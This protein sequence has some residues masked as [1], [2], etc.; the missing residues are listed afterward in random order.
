MRCRNCGF[1][2]IDCEP[3][4]YASCFYCAFGVFSDR[5]CEEAG[6]RYVYDIHE[7]TGGRWEKVRE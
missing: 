3:N 7:R 5:E 2:L 1:E 6:W 4:P